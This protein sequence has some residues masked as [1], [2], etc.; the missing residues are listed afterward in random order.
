[1]AAAEAAAAAAAAAAEHSESPFS[2]MPNGHAAA[3]APTDLAIHTCPSVGGLHQPNTAATAAASAA[4]G[5]GVHLAL[6]GSDNVV[7]SLGSAAPSAVSAAV[8]SAKTG[9]PV[10]LLDG[11]WKILTSYLQVRNKSYSCNYST[12]K[13]LPA[14]FNLWVTVVARHAGWAWDHWATD[15]DCGWFEYIS[16]SFGVGLHR[17]WVS[18]SSQSQLPGSACRR[19][20]RWYALCTCAHCLP[21]P[22]EP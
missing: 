14:W 6:T 12:C 13:L 17:C 7:F 21:T 10:L 15:F 9:G 22:T 20:W 18:G 1:M 4:A 16:S 2:I 11:M 8:G 3:G 19:C 5:G